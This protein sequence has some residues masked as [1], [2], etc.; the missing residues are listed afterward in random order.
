MRINE[1]TAGTIYQPRSSYNDVFIVLDTKTLY[2][3]RTDCASQSSTYTPTGSTAGCR[4][5]IGVLVA[6]SY[7]VEDLGS[8]NVS[9]A[10][11]KAKRGQ[12]ISDTVY[13]DI[14]SPMQIKMT[15]AQWVADQEAL[16][17]TRQEEKQRLE[18][19]SARRK[20]DVVRIEELASCAGHPM[21]VQVG[22]GDN[23]SVSRDTLLTLMEKLGKLSQ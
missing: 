11:S 9:D 2:S 15:R 20:S 21:R 23:V 16:K 5:D 14:V 4:H 19:A 13:F 12:R 3:M 6:R 8:I 18:R 10:I 22:V 7:D 1:L 17:A